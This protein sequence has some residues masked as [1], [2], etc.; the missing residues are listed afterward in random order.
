LRKRNLCVSTANRK[1]STVEYA[2]L[3]NILFSTQLISFDSDEF[4]SAIAKTVQDAPKLIEAGFDYV[5]EFNEVKIFKKR[6]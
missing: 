2:K 4:F 3:K 1:Y 5:C 6:K